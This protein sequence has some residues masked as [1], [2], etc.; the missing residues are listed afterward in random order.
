M[1]NAGTGLT[2]GQTSADARSVII[3]QSHSP[4]DL[5]ISTGAVLRKKIAVGLFPS[6]PRNN[7]PTK[8]EG[9][10]FRLSIQIWL[11]KFVLRTNTPKW[12]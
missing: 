6:L 11:S 2:A 9:F 3:G 5:K 7:P 10:V 12:V 4:S 1:R 8:S